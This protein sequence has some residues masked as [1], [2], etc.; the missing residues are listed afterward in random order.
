M[1]SVASYLFE[2]VVRARTWAYD[3]QVLSAVKVD[4]PVISVGNLVA[5]GTGK[6]PVIA[7]LVAAAAERGKKCVVVS[8]GYKSE[9]SGVARVGESSDRYYGDEPEML[10]QRYP[11]LAIFLAADR[12]A[13]CERAI[14]E[15]QP[16]MI[17]ADDAFQHRRLA[18]D[19]DVVVID[20]LQAD[21]DYEFLPKGFARES[22][23]ALKRAHLVIISKSNM[24]D[25][26]RIKELRER[27]GQAN[28]QLDSQIYLSEYHFAGV[29]GLK[30]DRDCNGPVFL[31]SAIGR[32]RGF[33]R[34]LQDAGYEVRGH[35]IYPDHYR[36]QARDIEEIELA[37]LRSGAQAVVV[38]EKDAVKLKRLEQILLY[39]FL[40]ARL[41][42]K[43]D[44]PQELYERI[45]S[46]CR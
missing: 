4:R 17:L 8:R 46:V 38:T 6:T 30:R 24:V 42:I 23:D 20:A 40:V 21:S 31:A 34:L 3:Q 10:Q 32:P 36:F 19:L 1:I 11:E 22:W 41:E 5:G 16:D 9:V 39:P 26:I 15:I 7:A 27:I 12:V 29:K 28:P 25:P 45:F 14:R 43:F 13:A 18:R 37:R 35:K 2:K 44:R 33:E